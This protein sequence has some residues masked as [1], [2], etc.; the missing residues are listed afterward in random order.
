MNERTRQLQDQ[1]SKLVVEARSILEKAHAEK[2]D[3]NQEETNRYEAIFSEIG[4]VRNQIVRED[5]VAAEEARL[6]TPMPTS[7]ARDTPIDR[8]DDRS[9]S[10]AAEHP[11]F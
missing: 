10:A 8:L 6:R 9:R 3:I 7:A 1:L 11:M 2:R 4:T 5:Q